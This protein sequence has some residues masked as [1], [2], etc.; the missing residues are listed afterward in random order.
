ML[1]TRGG[2]SPLLQATTGRAQALWG[3]WIAYHCTNQRE[4]ET[5]IHLDMKLNYPTQG[6]L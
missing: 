4:R 1:K 2:L 3:Y 5:L 6:P